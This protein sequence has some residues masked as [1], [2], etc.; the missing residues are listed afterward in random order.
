MAIRYSLLAV[1]VLIAA[2]TLSHATVF[3]ATD[4]WTF[5]SVGTH[6]LSL[7]QFSPA[8]GTLNS[9]T[10]R[11]FGT[12]SGTFAADNDYPSS[13]TVTAS[14]QHDFQV[15]APGVTANGGDTWS[16]S[17]L[18][19]NENGDGLGAFDPTGPDGT[20]WGTVSSGEYAATGSP[21]TVSNALWGAYQG[22]GNVL[23]GLNSQTFTSEITGS[24]PW[25]NADTAFFLQNSVTNPSLNVRVQVDYNYTPESPSVPEPTT[26]ALLGLGIFGVGAR[27]RR[28]KAAAAA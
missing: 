8:L 25:Y 3:S 26:L 2:T 13:I 20:N 15:I 23:F 24:A 1:V 11:V 17:R 12:G 6:N 10:V 22:S 28:R 21:F 27:A 9:V 7:S 16:D 18:L 4:N 19:S 5:N 14:M